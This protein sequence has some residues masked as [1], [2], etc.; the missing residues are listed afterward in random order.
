MEYSSALVTKAALL[1]IG[2]LC[3]SETLIAGIL[4]VPEPD[5]GLGD[6]NDKVWCQPSVPQITSMGFLTYRVG[7][8]LS[9]A[10]RVG[11]ICLPML[12]RAESA[13]LLRSGELA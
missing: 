6:L 11:I 1:P 3:T 10:A 13:G 4:S 2:T 8:R 9:S 12:R 5:S 7:L